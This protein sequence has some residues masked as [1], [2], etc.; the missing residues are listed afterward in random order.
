MNLIEALNIFTMA[1]AVYIQGDHGIECHALDDPDDYETPVGEYMSV[2][3][4]TLRLLDLVMTYGAEHNSKEVS[5]A[6]SLVWEEY[7]TMLNFVNKYNL[8]L[9]AVND[10]VGPFFDAIREWI[11]YEA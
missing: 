2:E 3:G 9:Q 1:A 10:T 8:G 4:A 7:S 5:Q 6:L 11:G